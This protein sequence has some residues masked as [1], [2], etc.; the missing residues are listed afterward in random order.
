MDQ[1]DK[2]YICHYTPLIERKEYMLEQCKKYKIN[3]KLIFIK[4]FDR[5]HILPFL[6]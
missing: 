1:I 4:K 2:I 6:S 3:D 5:E